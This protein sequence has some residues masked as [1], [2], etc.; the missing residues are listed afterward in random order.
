MKIGSRQA[1]YWGNVLVQWIGNAAVDPLLSSRYV[2]A[3]CCAVVYR[4]KNEYCR[5]GGLGSERLFRDV[6]NFSVC[7]C[8]YFRLV[9]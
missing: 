1:E 6:I 9:K 7:T 5:N 8:A 3:L 2:P 4:P